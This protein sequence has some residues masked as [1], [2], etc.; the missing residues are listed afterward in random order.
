MLEGSEEGTLLSITILSASLATPRA[1]DLSREKRKWSRLLKNLYLVASG[2]NEAGCT[3]AKSLN[4]GRRS[5][6]ATAMLGSYEPD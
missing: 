2:V 1:T 4:K 6:S 5:R 3:P